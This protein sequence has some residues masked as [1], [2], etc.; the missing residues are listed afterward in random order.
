MANAS[1]NVGFDSLPG[2]LVRRVHAGAPR[3]VSSGA[4]R[5]HFL[6]PGCACKPEPIGRV[7]APQPVDRPGSGAE[8][9]PPTSGRDKATKSEKTANGSTTLE[10]AHHLPRGPEL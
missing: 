3:E 5:S 9:P 7:G 8:K 6:E 10:G 2:P 4:D 1:P